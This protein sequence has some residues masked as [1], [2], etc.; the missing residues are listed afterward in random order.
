M[1][2]RGNPVDE[3]DCPGWSGEEALACRT[4][5]EPSSDGDGPVYWI[6]QRQYTRSR[7]ANLR[8][9]LVL[10][11]KMSTIKWFSVCFAD[12]VPYWL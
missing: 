11:K 6:V 7:A 4:G 2:K 12:F 10:S 1:P 3:W 8:S 5:G 9:G